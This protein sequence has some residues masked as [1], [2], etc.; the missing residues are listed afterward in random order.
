[1]V[2]TSRAH[3][4]DAD[5]EHD[6]AVEARSYLLRLWT[7]VV[8]GERGGPPHRCRSQSRTD[9]D[10]AL[11]PY[12][13]QAMSAPPDGDHLDGNAAAGRLSAIFGVD[14]TAAE[15]EC[16][17]CGAVDRFATAHLYTRSPGLVARCADC[18]QVLL[19]IVDVGHHVLLDAR[20]LR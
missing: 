3:R 7:H 9:Q 1:M 18:E 19:R 8:R 20:G 15:G 17:H 16:A 12:R 5:R 2:G 13:N 4:R 14:V 11:W 10:R 6:L